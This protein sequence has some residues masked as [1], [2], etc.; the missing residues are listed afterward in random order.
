MSFTTKIDLFSNYLS[1]PEKID[2]SWETQMALKVNKYISVNINTHLLYDYDIKIEKD[3]N[4]NGIIEADE[5][6]DR[7]Q[8]KEILS[9]GFSY[10]F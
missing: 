10:K 1:N 9:I 5:I 8:F 2:V 4:D 7:M 3:D 6:K